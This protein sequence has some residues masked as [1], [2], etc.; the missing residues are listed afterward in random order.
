MALAQVR[1]L[2]L[3]VE[4]ILRLNKVLLFPQRVQIANLLNPEPAANPVPEPLQDPLQAPGLH[5]QIFIK[6]DALNHR[7]NP[8]HSLEG[9]TILCPSCGALH[10]I[11]ERQKPYPKNQP[12]FSSCCSTGKLTLPSLPNVMDFPL[13]KDLLTLDSRSFTPHSV[14]YLNML[15]T[16]RLPVQLHVPRSS[17]LTSAHTTTPLHS[18]HWE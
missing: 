3:C 7:R 14:V 16:Y 1:S 15:L 18:A 6:I 13:L 17:D 4:N 11:Q 2:T 8:S 5:E 9:C 10:W 12:T